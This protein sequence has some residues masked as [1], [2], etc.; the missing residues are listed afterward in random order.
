MLTK[1][2]L[3]AGGLAALLLVVASPVRAQ[4]AAKHGQAPGRLRPVT[5]EEAQQLVASMARFVDQ[6]SEGLTET[7]L[8]SGA[9]VLD[10]GDRFQSVSVARLAAD[11]SVVARCLG[12][13]KEAEQFLASPAAARSNARTARRPPARPARPLEEK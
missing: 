6:S 11:G 12:S 13:T 3:A 9:V 1:T 4:H 8:P 5:A 10:L 2:S 7:V